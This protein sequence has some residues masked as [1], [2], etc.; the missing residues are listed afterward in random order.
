MKKSKAKL[1]Q[2]CQQD[3]ILTKKV[4]YALS[5]YPDGLK[6]TTYGAYHGFTVY[7]ELIK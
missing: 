3:V 6:R 1:K 5:K 7:R 4:N 2:Y